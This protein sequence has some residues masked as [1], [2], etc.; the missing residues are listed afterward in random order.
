VRNQGSC[1]G[2]YAFSTA[3]SV[4]AAYKIKFGTLPRLSDQQLVDCT[5]RFGNTGCGG[6][7]MT[8]SFKYLQN[9]KHMD[10]DSYPYSAQQGKCQYDEENGVTGV[11]SFKTIQSGDV[12]GHMA[13]L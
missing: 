11:K 13:A 6:G 5:S 7:L 9:F 8:N 4:E 3:C 2:C 12:D 10:R 1:G